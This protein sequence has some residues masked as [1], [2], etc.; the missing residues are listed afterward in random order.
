LIS[1]ASFCGHS[2]QNWDAHVDVV[3]DDH[4]ALGVV[5]T[6]QPAGM[7]GKRRSL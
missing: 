5:E 3:V 2:G 7:L 1:D 4:L 6:V